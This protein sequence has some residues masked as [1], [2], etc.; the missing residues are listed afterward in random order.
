[1]TVSISN[2]YI[3]LYHLAT[4]TLYVTFL[5]FIKDQYMIFILF[6][7]LAK[8]IMYPIYDNISLLLAKE[9]LVKTTSY[10]VS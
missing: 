6:I 9:E 3:F 7:P 10:S 2:S 1:M 5:P 8:K 4:K